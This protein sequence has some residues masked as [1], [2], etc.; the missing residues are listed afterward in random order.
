MSDRS[1]VWNRRGSV[2]RGLRLRFDYDFWLCRSQILIA[3]DEDID[4][5]D[6][7][8]VMWW[9]APRGCSRTST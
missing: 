6:L 2:A 1:M 9:P 4:P 5:Y 8:A 3:V 7:N